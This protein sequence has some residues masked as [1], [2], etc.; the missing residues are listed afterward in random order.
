MNK[1]KIIICIL[2][3][4]IFALILI[5]TYSKINYYKT[6]KAMYELIQNINTYDNLYVHTVQTSS[7]YGTTECD[8]YWKNNTFV[9]IDDSGRAYTNSNEKQFISINEN[10]KSIY[11][12]ENDIANS[13]NITNKAMIF[14]G[15]L[16]QDNS[17]NFAECSYVGIENINN[18]SCYKMDINHKFQENK[19]TI[20]IEIETGFV[21]K[22]ENLFNGELITYEHTFEIETTTDDDVKKPD[23]KSYKDSGKYKF[24]YK[25]Y[26]SN[27]ECEVTC[28]EISGEKYT[29]I[30]K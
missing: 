27:G 11:I 15:I 30:E 3:L 1:K 16:P 19:A 2:I 9:Y 10:E 14:S 20:W 12:S 24:I 29:Y 8:R 25:N 28:E 18:K 7:I 6:E 26:K 17:E 5:F 13:L 23:I 21:L 22:Y 4:I